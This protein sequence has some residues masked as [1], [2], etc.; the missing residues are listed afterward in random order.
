MKF[1]INYGN[2][3]HVVQ[4]VFLKPPRELELELESPLGHQLLFQGRTVQVEKTCKSRQ[5]FQSWEWYTKDSCSTNLKEKFGIN[6][7]V[8]VV[9]PASPVSST[10]MT[11][12]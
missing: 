4:L 12:V 5:T 6:N 10:S 8:N 11:C 3:I 9:R 2:D 1:E 7:C